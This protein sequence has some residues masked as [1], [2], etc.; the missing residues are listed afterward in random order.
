LTLPRTRGPDGGSP[1]GT[2]TSCSGSPTLLACRLSCGVSSSNSFSRA[3]TAWLPGRQHQG[4]GL[5]A[6]AGDRADCLGRPVVRL[7]QGLGS[8]PAPAVIHP[9]QHGQGPC[10]DEKDV[11]SVLG[12]HAQE[13]GLGGCGHR[14]SGCVA[15][16]P[17]LSTR[18]PS[19]T[20]RSLAAPPGRQDAGHSATCVPGADESQVQPSVVSPANRV[21]ATRAAEI[22]VVFTRM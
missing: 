20:P 10:E 16:A 2:G 11:D 9:Q 18:R 14:P 13:P 6:E 12:V 7:E 1:R 3:W 17:R 15:Q 5:A 8:L 21:P 4:Q 19:S 22:A